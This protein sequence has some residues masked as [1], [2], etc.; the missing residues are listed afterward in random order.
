MID[1]IRTF[2]VNIKGNEE[3][4]Q[5]YDYITSLQEVIEHLDK[6]NC[7]LRKKINND[8]Y[9]SRCEKAIEYVKNN[10]YKYRH[11]IDFVSIELS[12]SS[13]KFVID[14]LDILQGSDKNEL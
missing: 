2:L 11:D 3:W 12:K 5:I 1:D 14:L 9:K 13:T 6:I 10:T 7:Q 4:K 8:I